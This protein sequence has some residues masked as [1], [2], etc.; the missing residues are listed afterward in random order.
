MKPE[1]PVTE[2]KGVGKVRAQ[3]L[4]ESG[5]RTVGELLG[6]LPSRYE[7]RTVTGGFELPVPETPV[8]LQATVTAKGT[9]RRIR[10]G[11]S[12]FVLPV[13]WKKENGS[14]PVQ[15]IK[16]EIVWFNQPYLG[17][18][19]SAGETFLFFGKITKKDKECFRMYQPK[20]AP[21]DKRKT[22]MRITPVY[23]K[24]EG[25]GQATLVSMIRQAFETFEV[26]GIDHNQFGGPGEPL[27]E[28]LRRDYGLT[29]Y[30]DT[31][32]GIH[33]PDSHEQLQDARRRLKFE[34]G[35]RIA[36]GILDIRESGSGTRAVIRDFTP[37]RAF[38]RNLPYELTGSQHRVLNEIFA[39]LGGDRA[40]NRMLQG[41]VGSGKTV[42]AIVCAYIMAVSG[43]QTAY[44]A[45]TEILAEQHARNFSQM[46]EP[47]GIKTA[48]LTGSLKP[49]QARNIREQLQSGEIQ[50]VIGT[51][52]LIQD[53]TEY[54]NPGLVI[55]D[56]QHRFGVRQRGQL[57]SKGGCHTLVM[58]A[59]PI[60]RS[61][62]LTLYGDLDLSVIDELPAGRKKIKTYFYTTKAMPKILGFI[63]KQIRSG[64]QAFVVCPFIEESEGLPDV[65]DVERVCKNIR[66]YADGR[67]KTEALHSKQKPEQKEKTIRRFADGK[68]DVLV[69]TSI[70]EV[71]VDVPN[72][73]AILV[74]SA[75]RFGLAQLHQLRGR[76]GRSGIQS[77]CFLVS[78]NLNE[79]TIERMKIIVNSTD[80][81]KIALAD[82]KLRGPGEYFG[83]RQ[84]GFG[85]LKLLDPMAEPEL[86]G[87]CTQAAAEVYESGKQEDMILKDRMLA[88]FDEKSREISMT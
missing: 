60:P 43:Y 30:L 18:S 72:V 88:E 74:M 52:A 38:I 21:L 34:E 31:V 27:P 10:R 29:G 12:L 7:D 41:D 4:E 66:K 76:A 84:H 22:F 85:G 39:D 5:I 14:D 59:T 78:D 11:M 46:L 83:F 71:G 86:F 64:H 65:A 68:T 49:A 73:T 58:S 80:G 70:I 28:H 15:G 62:A 32:H 25:I 82:Y 56:E 2:L 24:L 69:A 51:H 50:V 67:F 54:Y 44:M 57:T 17:G 36:L 45:P 42:I 75:D 87:Q 40:M 16:G 1:T 63:E 55:T 53:N 61:T 79:T 6:L 47:Y 77:Y 35:L 37:A 8:T 19:F 81:Q 13:I 9:V 33:M 23:P 20:F 26:T 3:K 48:L